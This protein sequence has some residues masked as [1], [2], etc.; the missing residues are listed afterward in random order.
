MSRPSVSFAKRMFALVTILQQLSFLT[1]QAATT[2]RAHAQKVIPAF[3]P[4]VETAAA[5]TRRH[6]PQKAGIQKEQ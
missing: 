2:R 6:R 3:L 5:L 1:P 4:P